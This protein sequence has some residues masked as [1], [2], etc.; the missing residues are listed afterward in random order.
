MRK[1][2]FGTLLGVMLAGVFV[3]AWNRRPAGTTAE[4]AAHAL[5]DAA[6]VEMLLE[7]MKVAKLDELSPLPVEPF[8]IPGASVDVMRVRLEETY[9]V[10]GIGRDTVELHGWIAA[11][12][13]NARPARG[14][15]DVRWGTAVSDTEFVG[16]ELRGESAKFGPVVVRINHKQPSKGQVGALEFSIPEALALNNA[17]KSFR[18][19]ETDTSEPAAPA[20]PAPQ[21]QTADQRAIAQVMS[22]L[23]A[24]LERRDAAGFTKDF[25]A[26]FDYPG[27]ARPGVEIRNKADYV[28][29][30]KQQLSN[31]RSMKVNAR[32]PTIRVTGAFARVTARGTNTVV[33]R[34]GEGGDTPWS[35]ALHL[36]KVGR[37]WRITQNQIRF[38][39]VADD[40]ENI[41]QQELRRR[42]ASCRASLSIEV[43]MPKLDLW[44]ESE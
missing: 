12:I 17:Y 14:E 35:A 29:D 5:T 40:D 19:P 41:S 8:K 4:A 1:I 44:M 27:S 11:R 32:P 39:V 23:W 38:N 15:T 16:M 33:P 37:R 36:Q 9:E 42:A 3:A 31:V 7:E 30:L 34:E 13:D 20:A 2:L 6:R 25:A 18:A 10:E 26:D 21:R 28:A 22:D 24:A 43:H